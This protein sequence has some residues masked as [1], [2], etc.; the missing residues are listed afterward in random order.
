MTKVVCV[1]ECETKPILGKIGDIFYL[2]TTTIVAVS[3]G[4]WYGEMYKKDKNENLIRIGIC[5]L[6][7]FKSVK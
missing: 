2:D 1:R 7:R 6:G 3:D 5:C 4:D